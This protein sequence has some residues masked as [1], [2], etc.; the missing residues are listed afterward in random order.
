[1]TLF[2]QAGL[3]DRLKWLLDCRYVL[4]LHHSGYKKIKTHVLVQDMLLL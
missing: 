2:L 3:I 1:M 4:N